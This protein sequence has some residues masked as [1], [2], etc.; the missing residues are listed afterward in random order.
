MKFCTRRCPAPLQKLAY[1]NRTAFRAK[2]V[3][4]FIR[5]SPTTAWVAQ[6]VERVT[7]I[8]EEQSQGRGFEP[9]LGLN[10]RVHRKVFLHILSF[11]IF[12]TMIGSSVR[13]GV[14]SHVFISMFCTRA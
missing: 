6:S 13:S 1:S 10:S 5:R 14:P 11:M 3:P 12:S 7:L 9:R 4:S 8:N 2:Y